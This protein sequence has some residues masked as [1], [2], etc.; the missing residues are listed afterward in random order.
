MQS[1]RIFVSVGEESGDFYGSKLAREI[2][3]IS[4]ETVI[5]GIGGNKMRKEGVEIVEDIK[6]L[7][8]LGLTEVISHIPEIL[9]ILKRVKKFLLNFNPD[10]IILIDFP[11]FNFR[12]AKFAK[13]IGIKVYYYISPQIWAWRQSRVNFIKNFV[14]RMYVIFP[15]E[16]KFYKHFGVDV[17]FVGHPVANRVKDYI[18]KNQTEIE[19]NVIG[20]LPGSRKREIKVHLPIILEALKLLKR[21]FKNLKFLLPVAENLDINFVKDIIGNSINI[22]ILHG[23]SFKVMNLANFLISSSGTATLEASLF[24]KPVIIIYRVNILSYILG[25][26]LIKVPYIGMPNLLLGQM[27]NPEL[28]QNKCNPYNIYLESVKLIKNFLRYY[29]ISQKNLS[30]MSILF[31]SN[32]YSFVKKFIDN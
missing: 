4:P 9:R 26:M 23:E 32:P 20:I 25:R 28:I 14:D 1:K 15:F 7:S 30:L 2:K 11:D 12:L 31:K 16:E 21:R 18:E 10:C 24:G 29:T 13:S 5:F 8:V 19:E 17:E 27:N 22:E 3:N 6:N